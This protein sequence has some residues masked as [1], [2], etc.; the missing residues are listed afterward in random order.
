MILAADADEM[1]EIESSPVLVFLCFVHNSLVEKRFLLCRCRR[2][3]EKFR[4][5]GRIIFKESGIENRLR[6][7]K[8]KRTVFYIL[9]R[10]YGG[11]RKAAKARNRET[12]FAEIRPRL[13]RKK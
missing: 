2:S 6:A 3:L 9:R 7:I 10:I 8:Q 11:A 13:T 1:G 4:R 12:F 5:V